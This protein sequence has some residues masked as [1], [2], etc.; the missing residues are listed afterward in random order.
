MS[1][2]TLTHV[3]RAIHKCSHVDRSEQLISCT[4]GVVVVVRQRAPFVWQ[5][6][7]I[8]VFELIR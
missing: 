3:G 4:L 5:M 6:P 1:L 8:K 2:D 7:I